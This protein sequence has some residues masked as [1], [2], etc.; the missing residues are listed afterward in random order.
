M[1]FY[2]PV[3]KQ[4]VFTLKNVEI[5]TAQLTEFSRINKAVIRSSYDFGRIALNTTCGIY[6]TLMPCRAPWVK[7]RYMYVFETI[8]S[9][10]WRKRTVRE[11]GRSNFLWPKNLGRMANFRV[12]RTRTYVTTASG[13]LSRV[14]VPPR[15]PRL[16][17]LKMLF[18]AVRAVRVW[19]PCQAYSHDICSG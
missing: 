19:F 5:I 8:A 6:L 10:S 1:F 15:A 2:H 11:C 12:G 9:R 14:R 3:Q 17:L 16:L 7:Q 4:Q 18:N 13:A